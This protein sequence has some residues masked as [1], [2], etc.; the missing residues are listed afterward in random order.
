MTSW[1]GMR[2]GKQQK[3]KGEWKNSTE[4]ASTE[5]EAFKTG[6]Q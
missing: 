1:E 4:T 5:E 6:C 3:G 2:E